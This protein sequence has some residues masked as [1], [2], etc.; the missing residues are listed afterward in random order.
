MISNDP[1]ASAESGGTFDLCGARN[2][3]IPAPGA[4]MRLRVAID[5]DPSVLPRLMGFFQNLNVTPRRVVDCGDDRA[6]APVLV[7]AAGAWAD[8]VA[9]AWGAAAIGLQP[10][11]PLLTLSS[12][13]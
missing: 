2:P 8:E 7:N 11:W 1:A 5:G 10:R 13:W 4:L 6:E 12:P 9:V 3:D